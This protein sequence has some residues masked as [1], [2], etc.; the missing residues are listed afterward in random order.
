MAVVDAHRLIIQIEAS[1]AQVLDALSGSFSLT[2]SDATY[3]LGE[4]CDA[5]AGAFSLTGSDA[6]LFPGK[7]LP[8]QPTSF[9]ITGS[10]AEL[11]AGW[12]SDWYARFKVVI[13]NTNIDAD[14]THFPVPIPFDDPILFSKL[15]N[16]NKKIAVT[17]SDGVTQINVEVGFWDA[18]N[19]TALLW[20]S[21]SD[22]VLTTA[23]PIFVFVYFDETKTDNTSY[24]GEVT[25]TAA[26]A[27]WISALESR[28]GFSQDPNGD[29]S[30]AIKDSTSNGNHLTPSGSM[31]SAD[32]VDGSIG[33]AIELDGS[34]DY[35]SGNVSTHF[36]AP[37]S[38]SVLFNLT[39]EIS[40]NQS[41]KVLFGKEDGT[42]GFS[43]LWASDSGALRW[44]TGGGGL[45]TS[46]TS[47]AADT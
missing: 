15:G 47:W 10:D 46:K 30:G 19:E 8:A 24:V 17:L 25:D 36:N 37:Y 32:L 34:N 11:R 28:Y 12:L 7:V 38:V 23:S 16:N 45:I 6:F 33:K 9:T 2:G 31:T 4:R 35:L 1:T 42:D 44:L 39:V 27:V 40:A 26:Q 13:D 5:E 29:V 18:A 14:L 41:D 20:A 22:F 21:K 3:R 43:F